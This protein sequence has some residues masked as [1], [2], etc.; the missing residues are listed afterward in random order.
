MRSLAAAFINEVRSG[1]V[2]GAAAATQ[3][4]LSYRLSPI[5]Q[6]LS[7]TLY[8]YVAIRNAPI[9]HYGVRLPT[10]A[11]VFSKNVRARFAR[12]DYEAEEAEALQQYYDGT[13]D[14][15]DLGASTGFLSAFADNLADASSQVVAVEANPDLIPT[16]KH[17]KQM[18]G[19]SYKIDHRAYQSS[20]GTATFNRHNLT[21]GGSIHRETDDQVSVPAVS[22]ADLIDDHGLQNPVVICDIEGGEVDLV[23]NELCILENVCPLLILET[24]WFASGIEEAEKALTSSQFNLIAELNGTLVYENSGMSNPVSSD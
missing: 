6:P 24:H 20:G 4:Y 15:I 18:E 13:H 19:A 16:L 8:N 7:D 11:A 10:D 2:R 5:I 9:E 1:G 3:D 12:G 23:M 17:T 14:L 21:V 22:L